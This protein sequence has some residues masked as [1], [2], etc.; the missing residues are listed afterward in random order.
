MDQDG[1]VHFQW[2]GFINS[3]YTHHNYKGNSSAKHS[4]FV[5]AQTNNSPSLFDFL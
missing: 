4:G 3:L 5:S 1:T 2:S